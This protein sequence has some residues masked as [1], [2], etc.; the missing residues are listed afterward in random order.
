[1]A[2]HGIWDAGEQFE[3]DIF[4]YGGCGRLGNA[5]DCDSGLCEFEPHRSPLAINSQSLYYI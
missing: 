2:A 4:D 3:S 5:P 1:M